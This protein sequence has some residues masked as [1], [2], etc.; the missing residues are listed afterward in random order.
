[1]DEIRDNFSWNDVNPFFKLNLHSTGLETKY[2]PTTKRYPLSELR[3]QVEFLELQQKVN[4][5]SKS[6][7]K[8]IAKHIYNYYNFMSIY[9]I[10]HKIEKLNYL[11]EL[12]DIMTLELEGFFE[13]TKKKYNFDVKSVILRYL[14]FFKVFDFCTID[15]INIDDV[16]DYLNRLTNV[17]YLALP[18]VIV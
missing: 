9:P 7:S 16:V 10:I 4:I 11:K 18:E 1:M 13:E 15:A 8:D 3:F 5:S 6:K 17:Q 2:I 14:I 12:G